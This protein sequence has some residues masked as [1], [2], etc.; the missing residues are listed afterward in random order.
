MI[1]RK[2]YSVPGAGNVSQ[3]AIEKCGCGET[4][5]VGG[6][7]MNVI[8]VDKMTQHARPVRM[9]LHGHDSRGGIALGEGSGLSP[10]AA[11]QSRMLEPRPTSSET[12]CDASILDCQ[13]VLSETRVC[14]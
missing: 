6:N 3:D 1:A 12:N 5:S 7:H 13:P 8:R 14:V 2:A 4:A 10:G 9:Q 11:Q